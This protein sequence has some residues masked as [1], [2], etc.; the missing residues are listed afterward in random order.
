MIERIKHLIEINHLTS[1]K[2]A[3]EINIQPSA[4]SHILSGR[5]KPSLDVVQKIL[6]RFSEVNAEWLLLGKGNATKKATAEA[7]P[8]I[9]NV[10][11]IEQKSIDNPEIEKKEVDKVLIFYTDRTFEEYQKS[12]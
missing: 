1:S 5:N 9:K 7:V 10:P 6:Q 8:G 12:K 2:F 3:D 4:V 11:F